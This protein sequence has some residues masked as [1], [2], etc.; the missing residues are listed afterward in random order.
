MSGVALRF[1]HY[2]SRGA[3]K[4]FTTEFI[5]SHGLPF[6][7]G[8][9]AVKLAALLAVPYAALKRNAQRQG[10][11]LEPHAPLTWEQAA[12]ALAPYEITPVKPYRERLRCRADF[13]SFCDWIGVDAGTLWRRVQR[14][15]GHRIRRDRLMT[16][17]DLHATYA[18]IG[19]SGVILDALINHAKAAALELEGMRQTLLEQRE[20]N[21]RAAEAAVGEI[22]RRRLER[23][24]IKHGV[25]EFPP[26]EIPDDIR[27]ADVGDQPRVF[28]C[29]V[30][31]KY[32]FL[33]QDQLD[34]YSTST[35]NG[36]AEDG[37]EEYPGFQFPST[38]IYHHRG[39]ERR[40][41]GSIDWQEHGLL[42]MSG[43]RV[44]RT[45]GRRRSDRRRLLNF[46]FLKDDLR[47]IDDLSYAAE[48]GSPKS[49]QRLKKIA[50]SIAAL[51]RNA[52]RRSRHNMRYAVADWEK[53]LAYLKETFYD[54]WGDFPWPHVNV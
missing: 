33:S 8:F 46:L 25:T 32:L 43:Y 4:Q 40:R 24:V 34:S 28:I 31:D 12:A 36:S 1:V 3:V 2:P 54:R 18:T 52:K 42:A 13:N 17:P 21:L 48:W 50:E 15:Q 10:T 6:P 9:S 38:N 23:E 41:L 16:E 5:P 45:N 47:D 19:D 27:S 30:E 44:G 7:N 37:A 22:A 20:R 49:S 26:L 14:T 35:Q 39:R 11:E 53:D 29:R 51:T